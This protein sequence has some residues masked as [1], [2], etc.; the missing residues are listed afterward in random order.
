M[1]F[2][3]LRY[4]LLAKRYNLLAR[5]MAVE[6][7]LERYAR[8]LLEFQCRCVGSESTVLDALDTPPKK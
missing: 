4:N 2:H 3:F 7:G 8:G 5:Y 1:Y 6:T